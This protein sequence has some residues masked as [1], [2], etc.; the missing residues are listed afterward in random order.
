[1]RFELDT[2]GQRFAV[3]LRPIEMKALTHDTVAAALATSVAL[4]TLMLFLSGAW[5]FGGASLVQALA[6]MAMSALGSGVV[7]LMEF[8]SPSTA[9]RFGLDPASHPIPSGLVYKGNGHR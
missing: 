6:L 7:A 2:P 3:F 4:S 9:A 8:R 5:F 1:V